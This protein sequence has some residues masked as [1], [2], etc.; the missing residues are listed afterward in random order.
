MFTGCPKKQ[1]VK[2]EEP[3]AQTPVVVEPSKPP[4][5]DKAATVPVE[6][7]AVYFDLD[8]YDIRPEAKPLLSE[9]AK[10]MR[11]YPQITLRL[12]GH[13]DER[14]TAEYNLALGEKRA[15]AVRDYLVGLGV[16][17]SRLATVSYGKE[18]PAAAG[19]DEEAW[20]KNRRVEFRAENK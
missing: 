16:E 11:Q 9:A 18:K 14:G 5:E 12:E 20:S 6:F 2:T 13:C 3:L 4:V 1:T 19:H 15:N 8:S 7:R 17:R 10:I